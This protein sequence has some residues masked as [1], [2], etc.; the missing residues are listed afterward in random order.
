MKGS[1]DKLVNCFI[2]DRVTAKNIKDGKVTNKLVGYQ[3]PVA[4][5]FRSLKTQVKLAIYEIV[6]GYSIKNVVYYSDANTKLTDS[7]NKPTLFAKDNTIPAGN[8]TMTV[9]FGSNESS[10]TDFNQAKVSWSGTTNKS[11]INWENLSLKNAEGKE[12][13]G[14]KYIGREITTK[15]ESSYQNV[16]PGTEVK[17]LTL[18]VD[19]T[20]VSTDGSGEE[21]KVTGATATIPD[22]YTQWKPN[23][24][25]TYIFKISD[26]TNG[27]TGTKP[28]DPKGLYPITFDAVVTETET[29]KQET[30]TTVEK[31]SITAYALGAINEEY[32]TNSNIYVSVG[33][34]QDLYAITNTEAGTTKNIDLYTAEATGY[35]LTEA[36]VALALTK[37]AG[38]DGSYTLTEDG[39]TLTVKPATGLSTVTEIPA[40]EAVDGNQITG[41]FA[42]FTP[43]TAGTYVFEYTAAD[44]I[45]YY[46]VIVVKD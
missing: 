43:A 33:N 16:L 11:T 28:D 22:V 8:G 20:L 24:A 7:N 9:T 23:Y 19:Y 26:K 10:A 13:V 21:I 34:N 17:E 38:T 6:P 40:T 30:I 14:E 5:N 45:K 18:K 12:E 27:G 41:K 25:Y 36:N 44:G 29:G 31:N 2:S 39:K 15:S 32:K 3:D 46:K 42:K 37:T 35:N 1:V 4:F